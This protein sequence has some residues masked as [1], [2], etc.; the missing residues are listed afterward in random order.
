[1]SE[2]FDSQRATCA[3][4]LPLAAAARKR[5][6]CSRWVPMEYSMLQQV[7]DVLWLQLSDVPWL[8]CRYP[9]PLFTDSA[10]KEGIIM[11]YVRAVATIGYAFQSVPL[12]Y[13]EKHRF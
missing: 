7:S 11:C 4:E 2:A 13:T 10:R 1:M 12:A 8:L 3:S 9:R 5:K 6:D